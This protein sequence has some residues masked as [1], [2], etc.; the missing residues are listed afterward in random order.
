[1]RRYLLS[2][3][4]TVL[5]LTLIT[6]CSWAGK[7]VTSGDGKAEAKKEPVLLQIW[8]DADPDDGVAPLTTEITC[9]PLGPVEGELK[10]TIDFRDGSSGTGAKVKHTF[11]KPG[12]YRVGITAIDADGNTAMDDLQVDV[13]APE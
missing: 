13:E 6:G 3:V 11:K 5:A 4:T 10:Y 2:V 8:C 1:M 12:Q 9:E 7:T